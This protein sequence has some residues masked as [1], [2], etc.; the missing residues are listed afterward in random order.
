VRELFALLAQLNDFVLD[1]AK[2]GEEALEK[3]AHLEKEPTIVFVDLNMP[4]MNGTE[5]VRKIREGGF[6]SHA[7]I[8][9]FSARDKETVPGLDKSL[10]W[11]AKPFTLTDVL[12]VIN[13]DSLH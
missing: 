8:V 10:M 12:K 6:A 11:L 7:R 3:L 5:F 2:N 1:T 4:V 13:L 9:I